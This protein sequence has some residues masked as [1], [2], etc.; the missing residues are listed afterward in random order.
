MGTSSSIHRLLPG[1]G[2]AGGAVD[3]EGAAVSDEEIMKIAA[4]GRPISVNGP[5]ADLAVCWKLHRHEILAFARAV[6]KHL[7][8]KG[9]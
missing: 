7:K 4:V 6:E 5:W 8:A 2:Y 9:D 1:A 3:A